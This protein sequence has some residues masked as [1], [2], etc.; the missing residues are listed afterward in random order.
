MININGLIDGLTS[1]ASTL[2]VFDSVNGHEPKS[3]P[4]YGLSFSIWVESVEPA[5]SSGLDNTSVVVMFNGR[6]YLPFKQQPEDSIDP[7]MV[8]ALDLL[9]SA[10][11]GDFTLSDR[12]RA[13]DV[14]GME[15]QRLT[16]RSGYIEIGGSMFRVMDLLIP[17]IVNDA[18]GEAA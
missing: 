10:Y 7:N 15:G 8:E 9:L 5:M 13:I 12:I 11:A 14:R 2:G 3:T 6:I 17:C 16:S 18:W 4:G 1:H